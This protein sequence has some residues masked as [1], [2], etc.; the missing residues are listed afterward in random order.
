MWQRQDI[1]RGNSTMENEYVWIWLIWGPSSI[2][3]DYF[4]ILDIWIDFMWVSIH[5]NHD[6]IDSNTSFTQARLLIATLSLESRFP[7]VWPKSFSKYYRHPITEPRANLWI[8]VWQ[9]QV[10]SFVSCKIH[11]IMH[12]YHRRFKRDIHTSDL[13]PSESVRLHLY[14]LYFYKMIRKKITPLYNESWST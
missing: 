4:S 10:I 6:W 2:Y 8:H 9:T 1:N 12:L 11:K 7:R 14:S 13:I 3:F 5:L